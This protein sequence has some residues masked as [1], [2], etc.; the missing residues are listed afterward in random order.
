MKP[1]KPSLLALAR[2]GAAL[3]VLALGILGAVYL[4]KT[5]PR[6]EEV[7]PEE[8]V[9]TVD[10]QIATPT[11]RVIELTGYGVA[12]PIREVALAPEVG[13]QVVDMPRNLAR[14]DLVE[15]GEVLF[16]IDE[17]DYQSAL[18]EAEAS[19]A[20]IKAQLEILETTQSAEE[21]LFK[22]A[23]RSRKLAQ[24]DYER[25]QRLHRDGEAVSISSVESAEQALNRLRSEEMRL[26][27]SLDLAAPRRRDLQGQLASARSHRER[28]ARNLE[29]CTLVAP[30]SGRVL[31][32]RVE[33]GAR[34]QPGVDLIRLAD[35]HALEIP[36]SL[37][38]DDVRRWLSFD[39]RNGDEPSE[40]PGWFPPLP[41]Q[42]A[43]IRW[44]GASGPRAWNGT[45]HRIID[46]DPT[47]RTITLAVRLRGDD[48]L[49]RD[50]F[51]LVPGMFCE[52]RIPGKTL[53]DVF[54][55]PRSAVTFDANVYIS[56]N[57]RLKTVS[58]EI[59]RELGDRVMIRGG[60]EAGDPVV[61][62]RLV[63]PLE[64]ARLQAAEDDGDA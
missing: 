30:F 47:T 9:L 31:E 54:V 59:L 17:R 49:G 57:G 64:G 29:R 33:E 22:V 48:L 13:G 37:P 55:L 28:A 2:G 7:T 63:A 38:A 60:L 35:D 56:D 52:V 43:E 19:V 53:R 34:V 21:E 45:L 39:T 20:R 40:R 36:L 11:E 27:Q 6:P 15:R 14:G 25:L 4:V 42:S 26:R 50:D 46:F 32:S 8:P 24:N 51:P 44:T 16:R 58:V 1:S 12:E 5:K 61:V 62:T 10:F 18:R 3:G 41:P 23:T